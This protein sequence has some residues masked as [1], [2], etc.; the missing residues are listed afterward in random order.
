MRFSVRCDG[1]DH[2]VPDPRR[3]LPLKLFVAAYEEM[4][5]ADGAVL[6]CQRPKQDLGRLGLVERPLP[7][8]ES[9]RASETAGIEGLVHHVCL[10]RPAEL[11]VTY[12]PGPKPPSEHLAYAGVFRAD[13]SL[14]DTFAKAE[15]PTHDGWHHHS[16]SGRDRTFVRTTFTRI[17]DRVDGL[18]SLGGLARAGSAEIALGAASTMFSGLVGGAQ[19]TGGATDYATPTDMGAA[20]AAGEADHG[21]AAPDFDPDRSRAEQDDHGRPDHHGSS[22]GGSDLPAPS[23]GRPRVEYVRDPYP[24]ERSGRGV[25]VQEFRLPIPGPQRVRSEV[26]VVLS[27]TGGRETD[28]P[29]DAEMPG[30]VGWEDP[31]GRL[32]PTP[33]YIIEG[34]DDTVWCAIVR[35]APDTVTEIGILV[36]AVRTA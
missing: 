9:T 5:G 27:A 32:S 13:H 12:F 10:M 15:P 24:D 36:E 34:G 30:L 3:A 4:N 28:P 8:W 23:A 6:Q 31:E 22:R 29:L 26:A 18:L 1:R 35:P 17:R 25:L 21:G 14:D 19:G 33:T 20:S 7:K 11:V 16:L 2:P